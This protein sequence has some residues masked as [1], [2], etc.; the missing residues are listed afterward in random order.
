MDYVET[1]SGSAPSDLERSTVTIDD[2]IEILANQPP[3]DEVG[4]H[5]VERVDSFLETFL[6]Q[7]RDRW[8][9]K[10]SS[11][12]PALDEL[13]T[14]TLSGGKRLRPRF[15]FWSFVGSGG[16]ITD[17]VIVRA[18]AAIEL[19]HAFALIHDDIMDNSDTRRQRPSVHQ[20]FAE[21]HDRNGWN[22]ERRRT[23]ES[24]AIL[25]GD[26]CFAYSM[27]L[28]T[29][30]P[31]PVL[32]LFD[33]MRVELH[34]GQFLDLV[35]AAEQRGDL[36]TDIALYK[37]AKYTV[38]RPLHIG[39]AL[40]GSTSRQPVLS[41]YGLAVGEAFQ[42][43]DD[44]LGIFGSSEITGKPVGDDI[45]SGKRTALITEAMSMPDAADVAAFDRFGTTEVSTADIG[46]IGRFIIDSGAALRVED[47][48]SV[49]VAEAIESLDD[50]E[51]SDTGRAGLITLA[52]QAAWRTK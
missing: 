16:G 23:A 3:T 38:E 33:D 10:Y 35:G 36:A 5:Y 46:E 39:E 32:D 26:L 50:A 11:L 25:L 12:G 21:L 27:T 9:A 14:F 8:Q 47:R 29:G 13:A 19:L 6:N 18:G 1:A 34:V 48:I 51:L 2:D 24:F 17:Q 41:R 15:A 37:T 20:F 28:M 40:T 4:S 45:L 31:R 49:L 30:L 43:R 7:Q 22:G 44:L 42:L 52:Q